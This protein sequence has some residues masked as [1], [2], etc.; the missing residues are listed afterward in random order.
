[1]SASQILPE[2]ASDVHAMQSPVPAFDAIEVDAIHVA[3]A[4]SLADDDG[5][6]L[7]IWDARLHGAGRDRGLET[8]PQLSAEAG[9]SVRVIAGRS[10]RA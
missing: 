10:I 1:V 9:R 3:A 6:T 2:A 8:S 5:L 4:L 7:A